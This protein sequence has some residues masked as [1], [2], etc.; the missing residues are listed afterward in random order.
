MQSQTTTTVDL[1][2]G[3]LSNP[4]LLALGAC[5]I[6]GLAPP[7][8]SIQAPAECLEKNGKFTLVYELSTIEQLV[9]SHDGLAPH[10][11]LIARI[12]RLP[13]PTP[14][15]RVIGL[16]KLGV[17]S[18]NKGLRI[19]IDR[20][21]DTV[22]LQQSVSWPGIHTGRQPMAELAKHLTCFLTTALACREYL[23]QS[24]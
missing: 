14:Y 24:T 13:R 1:H 15:K 16:R 19:S 17:H 5:I 18:F 9:I 4:L 21:T 3:P 10:Y 12:G 20:D 8:E 2:H 23:D 6:A 7:N 22:V 11:Q